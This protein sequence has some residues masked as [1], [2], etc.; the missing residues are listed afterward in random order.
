MVL[1]VTVIARTR[2]TVGRRARVNV[3]VSL[4]VRRGWET[5]GGGQVDVRVVG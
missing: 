3:S 5:A 1:E 2:T 4:S